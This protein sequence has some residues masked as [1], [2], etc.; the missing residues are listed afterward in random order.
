MIR[1]S[2]RP[3]VVRELPRGLE[4]RRTAHPPPRFTRTAVSLSSSRSRRPVQGAFGIARI[5]NTSFRRPASTSAETPKAS[6]RL[7]DFLVG[8]TLVFGAGA[9]YFYITDT[10]ASAHRYIVIPTLRLFYPDPEDAHHA[11]NHIL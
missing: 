4:A 8:A 1:L 7:V 6:S 3:G 5:V 11:G 2:T 10:R 9:I